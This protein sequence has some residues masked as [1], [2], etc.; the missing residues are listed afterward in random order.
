MTSGQR[1][2]TSSTTGTPADRPNRTAAAATSVVGI[3]VTIT[4]GL[5]SERASSANRRA[6]TR[7]LATRAAETFRR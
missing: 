3:A 5:G 4:S 2:R 6:V 7:W 1:S